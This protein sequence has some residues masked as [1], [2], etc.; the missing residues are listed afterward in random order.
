MYYN[1]RAKKGVYGLNDAPLLWYFEH[2]DM[3][4]TLPGAERS[5]SR[6][7]ASST[8]RACPAGRDYCRDECRD[9]ASSKN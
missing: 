5:Q 2:R 8:S 1:L 6:S 7:S 3:I 9:A 4:L